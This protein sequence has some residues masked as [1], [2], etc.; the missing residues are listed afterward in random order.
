MN[1]V[2]I[3]YVERWFYLHHLKSI[4]W[5]IRCLIYLVYNSYIPYTCKIGKGTLFGYKGMG[6]VVHDRAIIGENCLSGSGVTIGGR[7]GHYDVPVIGNNVEIATGSK[8]LGPVRIGDNA[9][10]GANAV[11]IKDIPPNTVWGG[12]P[13]RLLKCRS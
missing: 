3:Y 7:S 9:I 13:A 8:I 5:V 6:V 4:A 10:I 12:V 11:V 2:K 1:A